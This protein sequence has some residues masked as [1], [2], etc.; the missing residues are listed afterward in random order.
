MLNFNGVHLFLHCI[1]F[2]SSF[3]PFVILM[4]VV[5]AWWPYRCFFRDVQVI[6]LNPMSPTRASSFINYYMPPFCLSHLIK[7]QEND[8][9]IEKNRNNTLGRR[10]SVR[11][12]NHSCQCFLTSIFIS[13]IHLF[14][15]E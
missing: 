9:N 13:F 3:I 1:T 14:F 5:E 15:Y 6:P 11:T 2:P 4:G 7:G 8:R 12:K 10:E